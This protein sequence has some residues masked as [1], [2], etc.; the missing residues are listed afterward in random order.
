MIQVLVSFLVFF[1]IFVSA[2]PEAVGATYQPGTRTANY[3]EQIKHDPQRLMLFL[4]KMPKGGD[5][6]THLDGATYAEN[7][8]EYGKNDDFCIEEDKMSVSLRANCLSRNKLANV[9]QRADLRE[10][11]I[12]D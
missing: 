10:Q 8:I 5:L 6:H 7:L 3:F 1:P 12:V 2:S 9:S 11:L 4:K